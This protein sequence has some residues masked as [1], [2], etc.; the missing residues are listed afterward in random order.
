MSFREALVK[1]IILLHHAD[2][3]G[4][5]IISIVTVHGCVNKQDFAASDLGVTGKGDLIVQGK[6]AEF[7]ARV[8]DSSSEV[9]TSEMN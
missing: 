1:D 6:L 8:I 2:I 7:H 4:V 5:G 9:A 3:K